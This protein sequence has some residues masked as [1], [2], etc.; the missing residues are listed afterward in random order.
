MIDL[1]CHMLP[2][3]DD[4]APDEA[5]SLE[6]ARIAYA[7]GIRT[8]ACTPHIYPGLYENDFRRHHDAHQRAAAPPVRR[9]HRASSSRSARTRI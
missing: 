4:G 6:M 7:D 5:T 2:G 8:T 1:H 9:G 3:I